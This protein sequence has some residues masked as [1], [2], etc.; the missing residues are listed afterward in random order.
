VDPGSVGNLCG[1]KWAKEVA[2]AASRNGHK[3]SYQKR[4]RPLQVSGVGNGSQSCGYDCRL[5]V[6]LRQAGSQQV[7]LGELTIPSV[8]DL[9][10]PGLLGKLS[11]KRNR[12]VWDFVTDTLY[13]MGPGDYD[14]AKAMPPGTDSYQ[15]ET[16]P[17]CH[18]VLPFCEYAPASSITEHTLTLVTNRGEAAGSRSGQGL[19]PPPAAPPVLPPSAARGETFFPLPGVQPS[20]EH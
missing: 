11:L 5:P 6:G 4:A 13:F 14:L 19:P 3:P 8:Q 18:S 12:A 7:S 20:Y 1:D 16:A 10:L 9:N 15:L 2:I 17:S